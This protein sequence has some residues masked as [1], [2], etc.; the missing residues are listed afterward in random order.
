MANLKGLVF[1]CYLSARHRPSQV[2]ATP[3]PICVIATTFSHFPDN[4]L[5]PP[6]STPITFYPPSSPCFPCS[7]KLFHPFSPSF[8]HLLTLFIFL[9]VVFNSLSYSPSKPPLPLFSFSVSHASSCPH[10]SPLILMVLLSFLPLPTLSL[11]FSSALL[12]SESVGF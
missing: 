2:T 5:P 6:P 10:Y 12:T 11:P 4:V 1:V 8:T 3:Q 7:S 9:P